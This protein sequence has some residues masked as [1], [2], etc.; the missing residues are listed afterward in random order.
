MH[1]YKNELAWLSKYL[2]FDNKGEITGNRSLNIILYNGFCFL[3]SVLSNAK[4]QN[5]FW[6]ITN[7]HITFLSCEGKQTEFDLGVKDFVSYIF[8]VKKDIWRT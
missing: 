6:C 7:Q 4:D 8:R 1:C 2:L 5:A 3:P